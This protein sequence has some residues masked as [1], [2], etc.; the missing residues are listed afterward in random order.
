M[1]PLC[2][3]QYY[4]W[5]CST[6]VQ[7]VCVQL[8]ACPRSA[9]F[10]LARTIRRM[11]NH[12]SFGLTGDS[13]DVRDCRLLWPPLSVPLCALPHFLWLVPTCLDKEL[14]LLLC[15]STYHCQ[16][17]AV[18]CVTIRSKCMLDWNVQQVLLLMYSQQLVHCYCVS[19]VKR[20]TDDLEDN[21]EKC[22][23]CLSEFEDNEDVRW[24]PAECR[25]VYQS[26]Q[27]PPPSTSTMDCSL[28]CCSLTL[29]LK[30]SYILEGIY[31]HP[32]C[33]MA[34]LQPCKI[35]PCPSCE[36]VSGSSCIALLVLNSTLNVI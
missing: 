4:R 33:R 36:G 14:A 21:T 16:L 20:S 35:F 30:T 22:T 1:C 10:Q 8:D 9:L 19:Q 18:D 29:F 26:V 31:W 3:F 15:R 23:I 27:S 17:S 32:E 7:A 6:V 11:G 5:Y 12:C 2:L 24:V 13:P 25:I 28:C 34:E